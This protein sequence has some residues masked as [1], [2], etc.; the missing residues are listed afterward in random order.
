M[1]IDF[2]KSFRRI[3]EILGGE[4]D[5]AKAAELWLAYLREQLVLPCDVTGVDN[6]RWEEPYGL[7]LGDPAEYHRLVRRQPSYVDFFTLER[8]EASVAASEWAWHGDDLAAHVTR[9]SDGR[10][11]VLGLSELTAIDRE[12][13][14]QLLQD[15]RIWLANYR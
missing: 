7:G 14:V 4:D 5:P 12:G 8:I 3:E 15:Y 9:K 1:E 10:S 2:D 6:F 13:D 11:F